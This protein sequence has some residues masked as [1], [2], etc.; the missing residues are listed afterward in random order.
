MSEK[1]RPKTLNTYTRHMFLFH[2][3]LK[4]NDIQD[5]TPNCIVAYFLDFS[6]SKPHPHATY[7][8]ATVLKK[9]FKY[10]YEK[11][12]TGKDL[13]ISIPKVKYVRSK[14]LPSVYSQEEIEKIM[15]TIERNSNIGKRNYAML[16]LA[17][18]LGLRCGD[19]VN[20]KFTDIDWKNSIIK[21]TMSKTQ[22]DIILPLLPE[23]GNSILDYLKNGRR[24]CE[25]ENIFITDKGPISSF[26]RGTLY[27]IVKTCINKTDINIKQRKQ[28]PHSLRHS[29]ATRLLN[30]GEPLTVISETLGHANSQV[31]TVYT[32]IDFNS[33]KDCALE[34]PNLKSKIYGYEVI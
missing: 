4:S 14:E 17:V 3:Y 33:L 20:L 28:G 10:L 27:A 7:H 8:L 18:F 6:N 22:K 1:L 13:S 24:I 16:S 9:Y 12:T 30:N 25:L 31:T 15:N 32:S 23:V 26:S 29:L 34:V 21:L 5:F 11:G 2:N 19:I